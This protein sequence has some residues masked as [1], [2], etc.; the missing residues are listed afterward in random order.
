MLCYKK[1]LQS[2]KTKVKENEVHNIKKNT[3]RK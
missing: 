1:K 3:L 2:Q